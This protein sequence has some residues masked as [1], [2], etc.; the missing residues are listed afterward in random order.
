H[1]A[2]LLG[3]V[4]DPRLLNLRTGTSVAGVYWCQVAAG[5][6]WHGDERQGELRQLQLARAV[7]IGR[8][9]VTNAEYRHFIL[10]GGYEQRAWWTNRGWPVLQASAARL[11][12]N[13]RQITHPW[14]WA[15][16]EYNQPG[17]PVVGISWWEAQ[18]Y[19]AWLTA[20]GR[21]AGWLAAE[22]TIRL[23]TSIEWERAAR[24]DDRRR[25]PWGDAAPD[26][27]RANYNQTGLS[28][29]TPVGCFPL[30]TSAS[31]ALDMA[32]NVMEWLATL[33]TEPD[34]L[35]PL[36]DVDPDASV[37]LSESAFDDDGAALGCGTRSASGPFARY[38]DR[39]F[40]LAL[41][42]DRL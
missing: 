14:Y 24:S 35:A 41:V 28:R 29:P 13:G 12:S 1:A 32:G 30:G 7:Q 9:L 2:G 25:Y 5:P 21:A 11:W 38:L 4:G 23:P 27:E 42:C 20:Q 34:R 3:T 22:D 18:A 40:R 17:Q 31:G 19:C 37:L 36:A 6:L 16:P 39:G 15:D 8:Y 33:G 26:P 10:A